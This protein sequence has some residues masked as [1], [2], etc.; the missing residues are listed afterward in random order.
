MSYGDLIAM[1]IMVAVM[2]IGFNYLDKSRDEC[3]LKAVNESHLSIEDA[4]KLCNP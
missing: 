2:M 1:A 3:K 4:K